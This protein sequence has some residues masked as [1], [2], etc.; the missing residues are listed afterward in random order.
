MLWSGR[1]DRDVLEGER[2]DAVFQL[3]HKQ[4]PSEAAFIENLKIRSAP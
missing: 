4:H 2:G 3:A 1:F